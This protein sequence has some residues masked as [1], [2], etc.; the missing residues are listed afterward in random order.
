MSYHQILYQIVFSTK[1]REP[2]LEKSGRIELFNFIGGILKHKKCKLYCINGVEDHIHIL[3][4]V[5]PKIALSNLIKDLKISSN[6][7]IKEKNIFPSFNNWQKGYGA[8]TYHTNAKKKLITYIKNQEIHHQTE[9]SRAEIIRMLI[10]HQ[11]DFD[12]KIF[13]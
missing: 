1:Y 6:K 12:E 2:V 5:N 3:T 8:F 7:F 13:E 11:I 4:S 10:E 9:N